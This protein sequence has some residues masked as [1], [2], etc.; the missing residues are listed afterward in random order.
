MKKKCSNCKYA[1]SNSPK[2]YIPND[3]CLLPQHIAMERFLTENKC[4]FWEENKLKQDE[5]EKK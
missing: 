5:K 2:K 4:Q 1:G 3:A